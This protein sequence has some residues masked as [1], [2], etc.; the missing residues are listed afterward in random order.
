MATYSLEYI[1][2][3]RTPVDGNPCAEL[4]D[5]MVMYNEIVK[6]P[7][8]IPYFNPNIKKPSGYKPQFN[9]KRKKNGKKPYIKVPQEKLIRGENA[10]TPTSPSDELSTAKKTIKGC[11]NKL[12]AKNFDSVTSTL[13]EYLRSNKHFEIVD[14]LIEDIF[15]KALFDKN[16]QEMYARLCRILCDTKEWQLNLVTILEKGNRFYWK[17]N[18]YMSFSTVEGIDNVAKGPFNMAKDAKINAFEAINF[19]KFL[20]RRLQTE[21]GNTHKKIFEMRALEDQKFDDPDLKEEARFKM[22]RSIYGLFEFIISLHKNKIV[23][24]YIVSQCMMNLSRAKTT[25]VP[26]EE[27][28]EAFCIFWQYVKTIRRQFTE[29]NYQGFKRHFEEHL[30]QQTWS[31]RTKFMLQ[32]HFQTK[33]MANVA[34][35]VKKHLI[36]EAVK[37]VI[38][39]IERSV[40]TVEFDEDSF[41][42]KIGNIIGDYLMVRDLEDVEYSINKLVSNS[43]RLEI[44]LRKMQIVINH[45]MM[46]LFDKYNEDNCQYLTIVFNFI[47]EKYEVDQQVI[48][49]V[50]K[51]IISDME[52]LKM[53]LPLADVYLAKFFSSL[54]VEYTSKYKWIIERM[55]EDIDEETDSVD[56]I[57]LVRHISE[58]SV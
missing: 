20:L 36:E 41:K 38:P 33:S 27:E 30:M 54:F 10:Y 35:V 4:A 12:T 25:D 43:D 22:K 19:R 45:I 46:T 44:R 13:M 15:T 49:D 51:S 56:A 24:D 21:F 40:S 39:S 47:V 3:L 1:L 28:I 26:Y 23:H 18:L 8:T 55:S 17:P 11:L 9:Q 34:D 52:D 29:E 5:F 50:M 6:N 14:I 58:N 37:E 2:S 32:D 42:D 48:C 57:E 7:P 53:D 16:Y 31:P